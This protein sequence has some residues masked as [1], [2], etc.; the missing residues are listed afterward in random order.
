MTVRS[1]GRRPAADPRERTDRLGW[2]TRAVFPDERVWLGLAQRASEPPPGIRVAARF[3]V[4]PSPAAARFLLPVASR[5]VAVASMLAYNALRPPVVRAA[6]LALGWACWLGA[7]PRAPLLQVGVP[8]GVDDQEVLLLA[9]LAAWLGEPRLYAAIG[10]PTPDP[11]YKPTLQLFD[12][13]GRPRG[14]AKVGWNDATRALVATEAATLCRI[15]HNGCP[16]GSR[17]PHVPRLLWSGDRAG[18]RVAVV[19]PLPAAIRREP[20]S[21]PPRQIGRAHV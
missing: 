18:Q 11:T 13:R 7:S 4:V 6:R 3:Q 9:E 5:R 1:D 8:E 2:V 20:P 12:D 15:H 10:V 17:F 14:Y 21:G 19:E 16:S